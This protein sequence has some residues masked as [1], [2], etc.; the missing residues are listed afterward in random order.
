MGQ[1]MYKLIVMDINMPGLDGVQTTKKIRQFS[2]KFVKQQKQ[3]Y[4]IVAHTALPEDQFGDY[5][6]KGFD[7]F[8]M[9]NDNERLKKYVEKCRVSKINR[10]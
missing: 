6:K 4:K 2:D 9:K 5:K 1:D 7:G 8:L 3:K 10:S